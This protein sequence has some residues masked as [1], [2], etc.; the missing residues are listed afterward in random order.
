MATVDDLL[1]QLHRQA[2]SLHV[3]GN[4]TRQLNAYLEAW[5]G[6]AFHARRT[7]RI[8]GTRPDDTAVE[9]LLGRLARG[10]ASQ[11]PRQ[12]RDLRDLGVVLGGIGDVLSSSSQSIGRAD[13]DHRY[14]L[15]ANI[16]AAL[17][18]AASVTV[19][20]ARAAE[21]EP[22]ATTFRQLA[23]TTTFAAQLPPIARSSA[24]ERLTLPRLTP[25]T[26]DGAAALWA[27]EAR[28]T[29]SNPLLVTGVSLMDA[30]AT[31]ALLCDISA[32]TMRE[33]ARR[34]V[35]EPAA[36]REAARSLA[37]AATMWRAAAAWPANVQ[38]GGSAH[39]YRAAAGA[40]RDNLTGPALHRLTL[41]ER[42][43]ALRSALAIAVAVAD[44]QAETVSSLARRGGLWVARERKNL[45]PPGV[46]RHHVKQDWKPITW[47]HPARSLLTQRSETAR[48][49]LLFAAAVVDQA[50]LPATA[51][52]VD[53]GRVALVN[54]R[55]VAGR[56]EPIQEATDE[57]N[58][59]QGSARRRADRPI[60]QGLAR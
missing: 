12:Y 3:A 17:Y 51:M 30:A 4:P 43:S 34:R 7:L 37:G 21:Q 11:P 58:P 41:R 2:A 36:A 13:A 42:A 15:H 14:G 57:C 50:V 19:E 18:A 8:L 27:S 38:L 54:N 47:S 35:V 33:A 26:V 59:T 32:A 60:N 46:Q 49:A 55:L 9:T 20:I 48:R 39:E 6:L 5:T 31:I 24:L 52:H 1:R 40:V 29:F 22:R 44:L 56:W 28:R 10:T 23:R 16:Q 45:R 25:D 53:A